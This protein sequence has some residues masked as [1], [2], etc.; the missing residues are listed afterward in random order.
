MSGGDDGTIRLWHADTGKPVWNAVS[1]LSAPARLLT[2]EGWRKLDA[3]PLDAS[4][5]TSK[6]W[7]KQAKTVGWQAQHNQ[8]ARLSC[9]ATNDEHLELWQTAQDKQLWRKK[10]PEIREIKALNDGCLVRDKST[11]VRYSLDGRGHPYLLDNPAKTLSVIHNDVIVGTDDTLIRFRDSTPIA[12]YELSPGITSHLLIPSDKPETELK[13]LLVG[14][15]DG[16]IER[17]EPT[18]DGLGRPTL[19]HQRTSAPITH[20]VSGNRQLLIA[21]FG[22]GRV[23]LMNQSSGRLL[24]SVHLHGAMRFLELDGDTAY[25]ISD[26]GHSFSWN[27]ATF[28]AQPCAL[29]RSVWNRIPVVWS[30]GKASTGSVP[31]SHHCH[32]P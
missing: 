20:L 4:G 24:D 26:L 31:I 19:I 7:A 25:A 9:I 12:T 14:F 10:M 29:T 1:F 28:N 11:V 30:L 27:I 5:E 23:M 17:F 32:T 6:A 22:D 18:D 21:G 16:S 13:H 2:H 8:A 15:R 3:S